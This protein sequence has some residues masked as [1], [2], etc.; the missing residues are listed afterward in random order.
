MT[1]RHHENAQNTGTTSGSD[2]IPPK[3]RRD[4]ISRTATAL[5]F[6]LAVA[7]GTTNAPTDVFAETPAAVATTTSPALGV[8]LDMQSALAALG[9]EVRVDLDARV[10][11]Q[12]DAILQ[13]VVDQEIAALLE[14]R[15]QNLARRHKTPNSVGPQMQTIT[16]RA[17]REPAIDEAED[18]SIELAR[19]SLEIGQ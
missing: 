13:Q 1:R 11:A 17:D 4:W 15:Q 9:Q 2:P 12:T 19:R 8:V 3:C 18:R 16:V 7:V 6:A 5:C 10:N 14:Q